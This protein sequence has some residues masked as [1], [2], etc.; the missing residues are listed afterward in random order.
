MGPTDGRLEAATAA[1]LA[2]YT[3]PVAVMSFNPHSVAHMARLAPRPAARPDH[4]GL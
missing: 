4:L 2:G 1:A 3:G